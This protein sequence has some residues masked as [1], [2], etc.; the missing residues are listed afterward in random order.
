MMFAFIFNAQLIKNVEF[1][2]CNAQGSL[3]IFISTKDNKL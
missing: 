2:Y 3:K 1:S